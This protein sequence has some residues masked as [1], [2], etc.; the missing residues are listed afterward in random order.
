RDTVATVSGT[1]KVILV[2][3]GYD[4]PVSLEG[5]SC[6]YVLHLVSR[7]RP[8]ELYIGETE[9]IRQ[10]LQQHRAIRK[11]VKVRALVAPAPNKSAARATETRL[12][13]EFKRRGYDIQQDK[14]QQH[15]LFAA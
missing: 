9:S 4:P 6:V 3:K 12:I 10:R 2:E 8:D 5:K 13:S 7:G 14:D 1:D 15:Q 11:G